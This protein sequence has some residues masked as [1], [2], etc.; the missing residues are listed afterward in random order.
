MKKLTRL[1]L[2][3]IVL[4]M[5]LIIPVYAAKPDYKVTGSGWFTSQ[6]A[7]T[8]GDK[9]HFAFH[10]KHIPG[11]D[12][13]GH[14][15]LKDMDSGVRVLLTIDHGYFSPSDPN[16]LI[17]DGTSKVYV[18]N[19]LHAEW[20]FTMHVSTYQTYYLT[21]LSMSGHP[22]GWPGWSQVNPYSLDQGKITFK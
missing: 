16:Y 11:E 6:F 4:A 14:G 5:A 20:D 10:A 18:N 8:D 13:T 17:L 21:F 15:L 2:I 9:C 19:K 1:G 22:G 12:W 7:A 3:T